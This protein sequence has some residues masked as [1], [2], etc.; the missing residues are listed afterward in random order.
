MAV[1]AHL[2]R[3][4]EGAAIGAARLSRDTDRRP[5]PALAAGG[6]EHQYGFDQ[7]AVGKLQQ[8]LARASILRLDLSAYPWASDARLAF[9]L[10]A[11]RCRKV[12]HGGEIRDERGIDPAR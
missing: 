3:R 12:T 11:E 4:A 5:P 9:E 2:A 8:Q 6:I 1:E 10:L 7:P